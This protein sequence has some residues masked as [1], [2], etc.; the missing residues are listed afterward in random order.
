MLAKKTGDVCLECSFARC[1]V[2][3]LFWHSVLCCR[4]WLVGY[5]VFFFKIFSI[6]WT[7][8]SLRTRKFAGSGKS[9][10]SAHLCIVPPAQKVS[11]RL[12]AQLSWL[13]IPDPPQQFFAESC[14][15]FS[16]LCECERSRQYRLP[17]L[18][19]LMLILQF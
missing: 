15:T 14:N 9:P 16:F 7:E 5:A 17:K 13:E 18:F 10:R 12:L 2:L 6:E 8:W 11:S 19:N 4:I 3:L 1:W